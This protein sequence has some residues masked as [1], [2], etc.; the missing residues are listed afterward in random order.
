[1][2]KQPAFLNGQW[3][4][5]K[6]Y[7]V[8]LALKLHFSSPTYD[9]IK[10]SGKVSASPSSFETRRDRYQFE[11]LARHADPFGVMLAHL[12]KDS[13]TWI[14]SISPSNEI[15]TEF[16]K[17]NYALPYTVKN[18]VGN[19]RD[20]LDE[21]LFV[22]ANSHPYLLSAFMANNICLE[23]LCVFQSLFN[24]VPYWDEEIQDPILWP[25]N[26]IRLLKMMPF[27]E[28]DKEKMRAIISERLTLD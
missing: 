13:K 26:R 7:V 3:S 21:N 17:R 9:F 15:Y 18:D 1:M 20:S 8:Y 6:C 4:G 2:I 19:L 16:A 11:K 27:L 24:Y 28:F 14:G 25:Q 12:S 5:Y 10:Y 23:T 22:P